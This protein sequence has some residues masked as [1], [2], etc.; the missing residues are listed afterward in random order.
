MIVRFLDGANQGRTKMM[1][2]INEAYVKGI[3]DDVVVE[4]RRMSRDDFY[5]ACRRDIHR[6]YRAEVDEAARR[7]FAKKRW[8]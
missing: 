5:S 1:E 2:F 7:Y 3:L 8:P 4:S 6:G